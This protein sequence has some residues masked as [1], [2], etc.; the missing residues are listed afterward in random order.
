MSALQ[1]N[2][3]GLYAY[4]TL[5]LLTSV[6]AVASNA[7]YLVL[8]AAFKPLRAQSSVFSVNL[9]TCDLLMGLLWAPVAAVGSLQAASD[10]QQPPINAS[11]A[12]AAATSE[13]NG[14]LCQAQA[15]TFQLLQVACVLSL[16]LISAARFVEIRFSLQSAGRG[17]SGARGARVVAGVWAYALLTACL[18]FAGVGSYGLVAGGA[19]GSCGPVFGVVRPAPQCA[20]VL[21]AGAVLPMLALC[22]MYGY[23]V[24]AARRQAKKGTFICNDEHCYYVPANR[25]IKCTI[26]LITAV[27]TMLVCWSP[28]VA[29]G[30]Y[31][32]LGGIPVPPIAQ[33]MA[34]WLLVFTSVLNPWT[35][36]LRQKKFQNALHSG[37]ERA[38]RFLTGGPGPGPGPGGTGD[39]DRA[40][41]GK[42]P[43]LRVPGDGEEA[44]STATSSLPA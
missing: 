44:V 37:W 31:S 32:A 8:V 29:V 15:F 12:A 6:S 3:V 38:R 20:L 26:P 19:R 39:R 11:A 5:L 18:P 36:S 9:A 10:R 21:G 2:S 40:S 34:T 16:T 24:R 25:Y 33:A 17:L 7:A 23:I 13:W 35:N 42:D 43:Q 4:G 27:V 1:W 14:T 28:Y 22:A 30:F 41:S